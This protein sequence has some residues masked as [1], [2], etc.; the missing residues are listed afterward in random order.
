MLKLNPDPQFTA[1]A[2]ITVPGQVE[3][4]AITLTFKYRSRKELAAFF[5]GMKDRKDVDVF[6]DFIVGWSGMDADFSKKNIG[7]FLDNYPAAFGEILTEY[8]NLSFKSRV[9]N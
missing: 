5:E 6:P 4:G 1:D 2:M 7:I 3:P 8:S 9:K